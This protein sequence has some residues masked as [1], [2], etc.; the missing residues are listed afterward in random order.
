LDSVQFSG[1]LPGAANGPIWRA[2]PG[3]PPDEAGQYQDYAT[4]A[5]RLRLGQV[6]EVGFA[7]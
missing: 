5:R 6:N 3:A 1:P 7:T 2:P 4:I